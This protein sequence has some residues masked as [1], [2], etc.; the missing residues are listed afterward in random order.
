MVV[1][2]MISAILVPVLLLLWTLQLRRILEQVSSLGYDH[3]FL[4]GAGEGCECGQQQIPTILLLA[5]LG[6]F[7]CV[8]LRNVLLPLAYRRSVI[9]L[10]GVL[11]FKKTPCY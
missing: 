8:L 5:L 7:S 3:N 11:Y 10:I 9:C 2:F 6:P 4:N 1:V